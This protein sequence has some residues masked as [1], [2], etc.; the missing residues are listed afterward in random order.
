L[1]P[2]AVIERWPRFVRWVDT[3]RYDGRIAFDYD[4]S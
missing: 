2:T 4:A 1:H 3:R